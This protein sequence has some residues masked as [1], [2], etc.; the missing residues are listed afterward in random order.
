VLKRHGLTIDG[1]ARS[2]LLGGAPRP[3]ALVVFLHGK[4]GTAAWADGET[5]WAAT[6]TREGFAVALPEGLPPKASQPPKFLLNPP[7]WNDGGRP[8]SDQEKTSDSTDSL[9]ET[10]DVAFLDAVLDDALSRT[11]APPSRVFVS[12]FSNGA[13][14]TFRYAAERAA[15]IAAI[16]PVAGH[17]WLADPKPTRPVPTLYLV[18]SAD[19]LI[20]LRGGLVRSPWSHR[21][22]PRPPVNQ[23]MDRWAGAL[24][25]RLIPET[26]S[27][28]PAVRVDIYPGPVAF[29]A[30][31]VEGL[32]H[33]WPGG[34]GQLNPRLA[35]APSNAI[36]ATE[37]VW[38]FFAGAEFGAR[39]AE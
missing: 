15:R 31:T 21:L 29:R 28:S 35:G 18:G 25:C 36:N 19:P 7:Q 4:G 6:A 2:Y 26:S 23:S 14:M 3:T 27:L 12:G 17:C 8:P 38:G 33:H 9:E 34:K 39:G 10:D 24:G 13:G 30:I 37:V 5:G 32:G 16:A 11:R 22:I 1:R 20:P